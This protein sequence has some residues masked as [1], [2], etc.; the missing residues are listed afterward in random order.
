MEGRRGFLGAL[1][2]LAGTAVAAKVLPAATVEEAATG[3]GEYTPAMGVQ[4]LGLDWPA[5]PLTLEQAQRDLL[6]VYSRER[7]IVP[8]AHA[9]GRYLTGFKG[10]EADE[11]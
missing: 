7:V 8:Y 2:A 11:P 1:A 3:L 9:A 5:G 10:H 6:T 4:A